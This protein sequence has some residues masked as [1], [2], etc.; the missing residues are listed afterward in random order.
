M[1]FVLVSF[2]IVVLYVFPYAATHT[3][4]IFTTPCFGWICLP[5]ELCVGSDVCK[6]RATWLRSG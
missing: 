4:V 6:M 5:L 3:V 2:G 1:C